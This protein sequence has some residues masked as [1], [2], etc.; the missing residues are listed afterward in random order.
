MVKAMSLVTMMLSSVTTLTQ[1][2]LVIL[3][4]EAAKQAIEA[5]D[6]CVGRVVEAIEKVGGQ[7]H[8]G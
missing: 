5:V 6:H 8:Y 3:V 7:P 4:Y 1:I 2:W